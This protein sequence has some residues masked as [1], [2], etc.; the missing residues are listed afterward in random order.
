MRMRVKLLVV[1]G[2]WMV[3][4]SCDENLVLDRNLAMPNREWHWKQQARFEAE[5]TDT[6]SW[7]SLSVNT[8]ITDA[9]PYRNMWVLWQGISPSGDTSRA[10]IELMLFE[11]DGKP[12][13]KGSGSVLEYR[14][15]GIPRMD[16]SEAGTWTFTLEQNMRVNTLPGVLDIG[17][18]LEK[19]GEKF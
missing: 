15:P 12:L 6:T 19:S 14:L 11:D 17:M 3:L 7:Y 10:R 18:A 9:Y 8:R 16:F 1:L 2:V 4:S 13:G 5:I